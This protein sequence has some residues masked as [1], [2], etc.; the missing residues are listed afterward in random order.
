MDYQEGS[1]KKVLEDNQATPKN[2]CCKLPHSELAINTQ[3]KSVWVR[4]YPIPETYKAAID[5]K[6]QEQIDDRVAEQ[7]PDNCQW[8][9]L[10][11]GAKKPDKQS[12]PDGV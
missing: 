2:S 5:H 8:N 9:L 10:L 7:A 1:R 6:V 12:G 11:L 4:Q 3:G